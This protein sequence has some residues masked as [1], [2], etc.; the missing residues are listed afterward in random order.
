M[1]TI[2][3]RSASGEFSVKRL[4][5]GLI[6]V[7]LLLSVWQIA[8]LSGVFGS[9]LPT[10]T[11]TMAALVELLGNWNF[12]QD[13]FATIINAVIGLAIAAVIGIGGG[14]LAGF[15]SPFRA[16]TKA[17]VEFLKPIPPIVVLPLA[18]M[19]LGPNAKMAIV[20][21]IL[22]CAISIF[23]QTMAGVQDADPVTIDTARSYGLSTPAIIMQVILP[24]ALPFI[25]TAIRVA[26]PVSLIVVV[27]AGLVGGGPGLGL[28][29]YQA[30][31][32][33]MTPVVYAIVLVLGILGLIANWSSLTVERF[34][35]H[36]HPTY[37]K[38]AE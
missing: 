20:L 21:V 38:V 18:V 17:I 9:G 27:V 23:I 35:L 33:G 13:T 16:A 34:M 4:F 30:Q 26:A 5:L 15:F 25:G 8:A 37:R 7:A 32:A 12:W 2:L 28:I 14:L 11:A 36:W 19:T 22:G 3:L 6:G 24:S 10:F 29:L 31:Q 1:R